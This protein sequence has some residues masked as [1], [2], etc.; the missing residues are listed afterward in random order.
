MLL[1]RLIVHN[2]IVKNWE[3]DGKRAFTSEQQDFRRLSVLRLLLRDPTLLA[4]LVRLG[5]AV[6]KLCAVLAAYADAHFG[7]DGAGF[8]TEVLMALTSVF[9]RLCSTPEGRSLV[10][11]ERAHTHL[12]QMLYSQDYM[13]LQGTLH[14]LIL[15]CEDPAYAEAVGR[16]EC[17]DRLLWV[18]E[19][20]PLDFKTSAGELLKLLCA[21][22]AAR[23]DIIQRDGVRL[24][25]KLFQ[26]EQS[27]ASLGDL[28]QALRL[29]ACLCRE[30]ESRAELRYAGALPALVGL[31]RH[32]D[33]PRPFLVAVCHVLTYASLDDENAYQIRSLN[34]VHDLG[35]FLVD[36]LEAG[37]GADQLNEL[38]SLQA[39]V[40]QALRFIF[41][42]ERNRKV[43]KRVFPPELFAAFIDV[44]HYVFHFEP[45]Q[46]LVRILYSLSDRERVDIRAHLAEISTKRQAERM[47]RT[48]AVQEILGQ[49]AF[50]KVWEVKKDDEIFA[51]KE[52]PLSSP[53]AAGAADQPQQQVPL[54][55][56]QLQQP[57][58]QQQQQRGG[59]GGQRG[60]RGQPGQPEGDDDHRPAFAREFDDS[61]DIT[62]DEDDGE[63][64]LTGDSGASGDPI[65][66]NKEIGIIRELN[67]PNVVKYYDA[68]VEDG[69]LYIVMERVDG[70]SLTD[71]INSL[72]E[73]KTRMPEST[74][75]GIFI[76]LV[77]ALRYIHKEKKIV[78]RDLT[79]AN[80]LIDAQNTVKIADFGLA[81]QRSTEASVMQ[82]WVGTILYAC[83]E[84]VQHHEYND[85]ADVWSLGCIL[86]QMATLKPPFSG[87]NPITVAQKIVEADYPPMDC[88]EYSPLVKEAVR[89]LLTVDP[90]K[91]P[92]IDEVAS[93]IAP[94]LL[95]E[96]M[97][98]NQ[99]A[100]ELK[101]TIETERIKRQKHRYEAHLNKVAYQ[102]LLVRPSNN[103]GGG[104]GQGLQP[105]PQQG[106]SAPAIPHPPSQVGGNPH[107]GSS[108]ALLAAS[109]TP[110][111]TR[112][113]S[114]QSSGMLSISPSKLRH[115]SDPT[116]QFL[117]LLHKIIYITQLPP[118][119]V[120]DR[121]RTT[122]ERFKRSLFGKGGGS[123][124]VNLKAEL[125]KLL[126]G[127]TDP[128]E[129][130]GFDVPEP[131]GDDGRGAAAAPDSA[132]GLG[133]VAPSL[134]GMG[135]MMSP[136]PRV[137]GVKGGGRTATDRIT[138]QKLLQDIDSYLQEVGYYSVVDGSSTT[139]IPLRSP[140]T[141]VSTGR[142][143]SVPSQPTTQTPTA[144]NLQQQQAVVVAT[145]PTAVP[146]S[147]PQP[148][149][150]HPS[151]MRRKASMEEG[152]HHQAQQQ[153]QQPQPQQQP[154]P[155]SQVGHIALAL[156]PRVSKLNSVDASH[157]SP[158]D[159]GTP[160]RHPQ[161]PEPP[162]SGTL[163]P[164]RHAS[165]TPPPGPPAGSAASRG[166]SPAR[167]MSPAKR[168]VSAG[169]DGGR[170]ED[171]AAGQ[172]Q[173]QGQGHTATLFPKIVQASNST[174]TQNHP[175]VPP[176]KFE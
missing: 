70:A 73:K 21:D 109:S 57:Q 147:H 15:L 11:A 72:A 81:R 19:D 101:K 134:A 123:P 32:R 167:R 17:V 86:Y 1:F 16:L 119:Y 63:A 95:S 173:A 99:Q 172:A 176:L 34:G 87:S 74:L 44:G 12:V 61:L 171:P 5:P 144:A 108:P 168:M 97:R 20:F 3:L 67:H 50:G 153:A 4:E 79:P 51:I 138:Y 37:A 112:G 142:K 130:D 8:E 56:Q 160:P 104:Q 22:A 39:S 124:N 31:L 93:L 118:S 102:Q 131:M 13:V 103:G 85:K 170:D 146:P 115:I 18:L 40:F 125:Q 80:V 164:V 137:L 175:P 126:T 84:I 52:L 68:F 66:A 36:T 174:V 41:S 156:P 90:A 166:P 120:R 46:G 64:A 129:L 49:G 60:H 140:M 145:A 23:Q 113:K 62:V 54:Q 105:Q 30:Q 169:R 47:I 29:L 42:V 116:S 151:A 157:P 26:R 35:L 28:T 25:V 69:N 122:I 53:K 88:P 58:Q 14:A 96:L 163:F 161:S 94:A 100:K 89:R 7:D 148:S 24:C 75:W 65:K 135:D 152:L 139:T 27:L 111:S 83:P 45:Y 141:A 143:S 71:R 6:K 91:R 159:I 127:S 55:L 149:Q 9:K 132:H 107:V 92:D 38:K 106:G 82:S 117:H 158:A 98:S 136:S 128:I 154:Q 43:F 114:A 110:R 33:A 59:G 78:H 77:M 121:K 10:V 2:R 155:P 133:A 76:Q 150:P 48:Y 165:P 162:E